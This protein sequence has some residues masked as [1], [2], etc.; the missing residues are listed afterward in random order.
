MKKDPPTTDELYEVKKLL[1]DLT[2]EAQR[3][4]NKWRGSGQTIGELINALDFV[5][6]QIR[7]VRKILFKE[8]R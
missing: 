1:D 3:V 2:S 6:I 5:T 7:E 4:A 8:R